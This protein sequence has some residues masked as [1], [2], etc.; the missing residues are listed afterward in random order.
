LAVLGSGLRAQPTA[1]TAVPATA[2]AP[3]GESPVLLLDE[4]GRAPQDGLLLALRIQLGPGTPVELR[5]VAEGQARSGRTE[6]AAALLRA[7]RARAVVWTE[8]SQGAEPGAATGLTFLVLRP[9]SA[10][11]PPALDAHRVDGP[12][13]PDLDRTI[14]LKVSEILAQTPASSSLGEGSAAG[15]TDRN[16]LP[17]GPPSQPAP[18]WQL[19]LLAQVA[20]LAAPVGGTGFGRWGLALGAG[21]SLRREA[22]HF[23]ALAEL[24]WL[25]P[26]ARQ[27]GGA[28]IEVR[29]LVPGLRLSA[30]TGLGPL[31]VGLH[32]GLAVS[33]LS[34]EASSADGRTA[35]A[36]ELS[37]SWLAGAGVELPL[38]AALGLA[39]DL[40]VQVRLRRQHFAV[41]KRDLADSG[42]VRPV[43]RIAIAFRPGEHL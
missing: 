4:P 28:R 3:G 35:E 34:A 18:S 32:T 15:P 16:A 24:T 2:T 5:G 36:S 11:G 37:P 41:E 21:A 22:I 42:V 6:A 31:W 9:G 30:Q 13:G 25:P 33:L 14:A 40:G 39:V 12:T 43:A 29:E 10:A 20:G 19:G 7:E 23:G 38:T 27:D 17:G 8:V 26:V 1:P